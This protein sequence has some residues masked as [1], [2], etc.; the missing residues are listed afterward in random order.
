MEAKDVFTLL[1]IAF[2]AGTK[3]YP[4]SRVTI[5]ALCDSTLRRSAQRFA[6]LQKSRRNHRSYVWTEALS[7]MIVA[8]A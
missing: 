1:R 4:V 8:P 7:G 6:P 3:S 2:R 5:C